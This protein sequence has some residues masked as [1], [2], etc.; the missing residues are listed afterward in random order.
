MCEE[1]QEEEEEGK[2]EERVLNMFELF[3]WNAKLFSTH[4]HQHVVQIA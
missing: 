1:T 4:V 2:R 3:L